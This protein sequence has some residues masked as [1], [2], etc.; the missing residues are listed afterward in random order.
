MAKAKEAAP[1]TSSCHCTVLAV[2][3]FRYMDKLEKMLKG[4]DK[5]RLKA[6]QDAKKK[7]KKDD[8]KAAKEAAKE[9]KKA[10][11]KAKKDAKVTRGAHKHRKK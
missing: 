3:A 6:I 10:A 5:K 9:A 2:L 11:E 8:E 4:K 1:H 7:Q